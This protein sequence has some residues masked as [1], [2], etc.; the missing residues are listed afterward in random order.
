EGGGGARAPR[1][2]ARG[3]G[4][5]RGLADARRPVAQVV[6]RGPR[7]LQAAHG[8]NLGARDEA[9]PPRR[10]NAS[11]EAEGRRILL[12]GELTPEESGQAHLAWSAQRPP[13]SSISTKTNSKAF[14]LVT[15][16]S[17][18]AGRAYAWPVT[19][20]PGEAPSGPVAASCPV[21][22]GTTT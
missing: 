3:Q 2:A 22:M 1:D 12:A 11:H 6:L 7:V 21:V 20:L 19:R 16:C 5:P 10:A 4:G 17:T 13:S 8:E 18:P 9:A 14:A 15:S